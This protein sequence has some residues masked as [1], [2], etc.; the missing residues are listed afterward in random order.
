MSE[1]IINA[2]GKSVYY[3][4]CK[5]NF[6]QA[7]KLA[8][9]LVQVAQ[10]AGDPSALADA[11]TSRGFVHLLQGEILNAFNCFR[12]I[13]LLVPHDADRCLVAL[14]FDLLATYEQFHMYPDRNGVFSVE[15]T[16]RWNL[17]DDMKAPVERWRSLMGRASNQEAQFVGWMSYSFL[18]ELQGARATISSKR[19]TP[20]GTPI[21]PFLHTFM[22]YSDQLR[23]TAEAHNR[24]SLGAFADM[25]TADLFRRAGAPAVA[26][27]YLG[28]A[29]K[30]YHR[31]NDP[32]GAAVCAMIWSDWQCA[33]FST[34]IDWNLAVDDS[35]TECSELLPQ[36]ET[37]EFSGGG[38][39]SYEE[40]ERLFRLANA[41]R[42][43]A[44]IQLRYGYLARLKEDY[45]TA[46]RH[47]V[48]AREGFASC[49]DWRGYWIAQTHL[50]MCQLAGAQ[51]SSSGAEGDPLEF[52]T[53]IGDWGRLSGS[54][55]FTLGLGILINRFARH[56]L[57]RRG[58]Y[59][60][61][62]ACSRVAQK[63][64]EALGAT[65]NAAQTLVDQGRTYEAAGER[66]AASNFFEDALDSYLRV[67]DAKP[68][69]A[70]AMSQ[71][72][73]LISN[74]LYQIYV[75]QMNADGM[76]RSAKRLEAL[77]GQMPGD[78]DI[79]SLLASLLEQISASASLDSSDLMERQ[80][81]FQM[82]IGAIQQARVLVPLYRSRQSKNAGDQVAAEAFLD[83][84]L[85]ALQV[86]TGDDR[87]FLEATVLGERKEYA[88]ASKVYQQFLERGGGNSGF[89]GQVTDM[90]AQIGGSQGQAGARL[91]QRR[92]HDLSL[93]LFVRVKDYQEANK[94]LQALELLDGPEW[95]ASEDKPWQQLC[96][97]AEMYEGLEELGSALDYYEQAIAQLEA[98]RSHLSRDELKT[99]L[100]SD[101]GAQYL[102][103]LAARAAMKFSDDA[104]SFDYAERGK[105]RALLDL[106]AETNLR[107]SQHEPGLMRRRRQLNAQLTLWRGLLAQSRAK[108][109]PDT[110]SIASF[111][112][113][114][115]EDEV[116]LRRVESKLAGT[117]PD[118]HRAIH[119]ESATLS[120]DDVQKSLPPQTALLEYY[121]LG[122]D[123]LAWAITRDE[124]RSHH[125]ALEAAELNLSIR[126]FHTACKEGEPIG[127]SAESLTAA[128][129]EP[130]AEL[131]REHP[132]LIIVPYGAAHIL[133][134]QALPVD[135]EAL[136]VNHTISYLPSA[137]A[138]QFLKQSESQPTTDRILAI[139][140]PT[141]DLKE[142]AR[143]AVYV[144]GL[145][146]QSLALVEDD[147]TKQSVLEHIA[148]HSILHFATHGKLSE[149]AP[150][151][152]SILLANGEE[153]TVY[154]LMGLDLK[155]N[156]V[157]LSACNTGQGETTGG[158]DVLGLTRG[159]LASGARAAI[160]SLWPVDDVST[161][162]LMCE[163]YRRLHT[164]YPPR[165][166]LNL[167]Q[168]YLR[169]LS[170]AQI[171][172]EIARL[173]RHL[174]PSAQND[175]E[176][177][178]LERRLGKRGA[179]SSRFRDFRRPYFWAPFILVGN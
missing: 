83:Q 39:A 30:A 91:Q 64:F 76:E 146:D 105:A 168:N 166:A 122:E 144:A 170:P 20:S 172:E 74:R 140:N 96:D 103:F 117:N 6:A 126:K 99:A 162:L 109:Q 54:F 73:I 34:P 107:A 97:I 110:L 148:S 159:L 84:A 94:H 85:A 59:E 93:T 129:L 130:F 150:L 135:G 167:A 36:L 79:D 121:F 11:L 75:Q 7:R 69:M 152:S 12:K 29:Q 149:D 15:V 113:K 67:I 141:R 169:D 60:R 81:R 80:L 100:A 1:Q 38:A 132:H 157:V 35:G 124:V 128:L 27:Q 118:F 32:A 55:G 23:A 119:Q 52:A 40:A 53:Q 71:R 37:D 127:P 164:G 90:L 175:E 8:E 56:W 26:Q 112:Q 156:L 21:E 65:I 70:A 114:I 133:P 2:L 33:P 142:A 106:M 19:Y 50:L 14:S 24:P 58:D 42:G 158:D 3:E 179:V 178:S 78:D 44:S 173:E 163:F 43:T 63:L 13:E 147:A 17:L 89:I 25:M 5:G 98:R 95:W 82:A 41:P 104:R 131:I 18:C 143:E 134:F 87:Y 77:V 171:D 145:F 151:N 154:E 101:K 123:L 72:A 57:I 155:A 68:A 177:A 86:T 62:L 176:S 46:A 88:R 92:T 51:H 4:E 115:A 111:T 108:N 165:Q 9:Q 136:A 66:A 45:V 153:L 48:Q 138:L 174:G 120:L 139:G 161:S 10:S 22:Q 160:V 61:S 47:A 116:E 31:A 49:E 125:A 16:S 137:S 102:Y 28:Q